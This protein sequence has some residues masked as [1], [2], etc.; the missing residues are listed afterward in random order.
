MKKLAAVV[1]AVFVAALI[2]GVVTPVLA[3][4]KTHQMKATI[5]S[6]DT[7]G[8]KI[9]FKDEKGEE[10]TAPVMD[11]AVDELKNVKAGDKVTLTCH[12]NEKGEHEG[13]TAIKKG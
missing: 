1:C 9:T 2:L 13:V 8:K 12:D 11:K 6:I 10:K 5:V 3:A 7:E 4:G